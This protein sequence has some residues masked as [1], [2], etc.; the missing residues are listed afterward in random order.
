MVPLYFRFSQLCRQSLEFGE[1]SHYDAW[2]GCFP[3]WRCLGF[4]YLWV[5]IIT[6]D[7]T[8]TSFIQAKELSEST[9]SVKSIGSFCFSESV[10]IDTRSDSSGSRLCRFDKWKI[11]YTASKSS[12]LTLS[13]KTDCKQCLVVLYIHGITKSTSRHKPIIRMKRKIAKVQSKFLSTL[14][15]FQLTKNDFVIANFHFLQ[16]SFLWFYFLNFFISKSHTWLVKTPLWALERRSRGKVYE[17]RLS[18]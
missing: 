14:E 10:E 15:V 5:N 12:A 11:S 16:F 2:W 6:Y 7:V 8:I 17:T 13:L 9:G 4:W 3:A 1:F 18:N